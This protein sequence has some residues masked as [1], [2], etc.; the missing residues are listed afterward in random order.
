MNRVTSAPWFRSLICATLLSALACAPSTPAKDKKVDKRAQKAAVEALLAKSRGLSNI[1]EPGSPSFVLNAEVH[2]QIGAQK[3]EGQAQIIWTAPDHYREAFTAP[4]YF[5]TEIVRDGYR[6]LSRTNDDMP[7]IIFELHNTLAALMHTD[8]NLKY[9]FKQIDTVPPADDAP[10]CVTFKS[11]PPVRTC[12]DEWGDVVTTEANQPAQR[13]I[14]SARYERRDFTTFGA[15]RFPREV[16]FHGGDGHGI[17]VDVQQ[18]VAIKDPPADAFKIPI[19]SARETWCSEPRFDS[20]DKALILNPPDAFVIASG[21]LRRA[22]AVLYVTVRPGGRLRSA[23]VVYSSS[24]VKPKT[25]QDWLENAH[26]RPLLCGTD[27]LEYE[28]EVSF[29]P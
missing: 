19:P 13:R 4:N 15:K 18:L 10:T 16:T 8:T 2:Y 25:L 22:N 17:E 20:P 3:A 14:M 12:L 11:E 6:Y 5:Y 26:S 28:A 21:I 23:M 29:A 7:L 9:K 27:G 24:P 1:E